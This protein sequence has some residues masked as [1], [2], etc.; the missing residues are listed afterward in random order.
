MAHGVFIH[1]GPELTID[2]AAQLGHIVVVRVGFGER[3]SK[4][5]TNRRIAGIVVDEHG[6]A[7]EEAN[8]VATSASG[9]T[10]HA[11]TDS[12]GRFE[13]EARDDG[14]YDVKAIWPTIRDSEYGVV[15]RVR[16][17]DVQVRLVLPAAA[18][19]S[20]RVLLEGR[21]L[22]QFGVTLQTENFS[23]FGGWPIGV[24]SVDGHFMLRNVDPG[25][26]RFTVVGPGT[27]HKVIDGVT[28]EAGKTL[29]LGDIVM[30]RGDRIAGQVRD[31]AGAPVSGARVMIGR[32]LKD[33]NTQLEQWLRGEYVTT[34]NPSGEFLFDGID[35]HSPDFATPLIVATHVSAGASLLRELPDGSATIDLVLLGA[36]IIAGVVELTEGR[37]MSVLAKRP[38]EPPSRRRAPVRSGEFR[39]EN[40]PAGDY[41]IALDLPS[42]EQPSSTKVS[43]VANETAQATLRLTTATVRL[44]VT[45]RGKPRSDGRYHVVLDPPALDPFTRSMRMRNMTTGEE[46]HTHRFD[47]VK[48]GSYRISIDGM[49]TWKEVTVDASPAEQTIE[50]SLS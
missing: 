25:T 32:H 38:D 6:N 48:P 37:H 41:E 35:T 46:M 4:T 29:D 23:P 31:Q 13:F 45:I 15:Q 44:S 43:V 39:F 36:G 47:Y 50:F 16:P 14:D 22:P 24:R 42:H 12:N 2:P 5:L 18:T 7:V 30:E 49:K 3:L 20:G 26:W 27:R 9:R 33:E 8:V 11:V 21:P 28:A 40:V 1:R 10:T 17:G 19:L 34:T